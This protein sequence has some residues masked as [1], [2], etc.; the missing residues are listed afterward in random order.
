MARYQVQSPDGQMHVIEGPDG[1]T[2]DQVI[3]AAQSTIPAAAPQQPSPM[4]Q[5]VAGLKNPV[6][7]N[8]LLGGIEHAANIGANIMQPFQWATDKLTGATDPTLGSLVTGQR[9]QSSNELMRSGIKGGI[10]EIG[11][12]RSSLGYKNAGAATDIAG[13]AGIGG[14]LAKPVA[15]AVPYVRSALPAAA[16]YLDKFANALGSA[17]FTTGGAAPVGLAEKA[18]DLAIRSAAGGAVGGASTGLIDQKYAGTGALIGAALP[19]ALKVV[20]AVAE[21]IGTAAARGAKS[22]AEGLMQSAL[23]P[24]IAQLRSGEAKTAVQ[25]LL[26]YGISPTGKGVNQ[27]QDLIS[28]LNDDISSKVG[29]SSATINKQNVVNALASTRQKFG[30]QVSP[31]ADLNSINN[32]ESDFLNHP[33]IPGQDIPVQAAQDMKQGTYQVLKGKYGQLGS[34]ETEAQKGLARGL[35]DEIANAVPGVGEMNAEESRLLAT[36]SVTERRALMDANKNPIGLA[37]LAHNPIGWAAFMADKSAAFKGLAA[38]AINSSVPAMSSV[39]A[40]SAPAIYRAAP[41][42]I[43]SGSQP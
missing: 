5:F 35:K 8:A 33:N 43:Q 30:N 20:G 16:P 25:T 9:P 10:D 24:T 15:A 6:G 4:D 18:G 36:L 1:A 34:A 32:V 2:P 22:A 41:R 17:G 21:P 40:L 7:K 37:M 39:N 13:T 19:P 31:T 23:K 27:L 42:S 26:D 38:R 28:S 12:D 3:A 14:L 29:N 11:V